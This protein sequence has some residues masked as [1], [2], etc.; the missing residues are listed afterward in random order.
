M[1]DVTMLPDIKGLDEVL[2]VGYGT[3]KKSDITGSVER[4]NMEKTANLPN[5]NVLQSLQGRVPGLNVTSPFRPGQAPERSDEHTSE[6]QS[7]MRISY[8]VFC[9]N[10]KKKR[11]TTP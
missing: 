10:K 2:V 6:L 1:I 5:Y 8:A 4:V 7:L 3:Q 11:I 9:F